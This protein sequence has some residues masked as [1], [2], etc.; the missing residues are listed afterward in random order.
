MSACQNGLS[1]PIK[2]GKKTLIH[3]FSDL[4]LLQLRFGYLMHK[5]E[6]CYCR[7]GLRV[8]PSQSITK[9]L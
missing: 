5:N 9:L 2:T 6:V 7:L 4:T 3:M 8:Y 1:V